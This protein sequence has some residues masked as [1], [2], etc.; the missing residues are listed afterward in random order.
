MYQT[1]PLTQ[2]KNRRALNTGTTVIN[3]GIETRCIS[4]PFISLYTQFYCR[5]FV[6]RSQG[7]VAQNPI[8]KMTG[9]T[10]NLVTQ[11]SPTIFVHTHLGGTT[12]DVY[13]CNL[14][15]GRI[16]WF[17]RLY[18]THGPQVD[19]PCSNCFKDNIL[20]KMLFH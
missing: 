19:D 20:G 16:T 2:D 1:E 8:R 11:R 4:A 17:S 5:N 6:G 15:A 10:L 3:E 9:S 14:V 12:F 7:T 13:F 18:L